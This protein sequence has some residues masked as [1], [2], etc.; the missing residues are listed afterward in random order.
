MAFLNCPAMSRALSWPFLGAEQGQTGTE[1]N[2]K[3]GASNWQVF[4]NVILANCELIAINRPTSE[5]ITAINGYQ[6]ALT[7][8]NR[9]ICNKLGQLTWKNAGIL[10]HQRTP[11]AR[12]ELQRNERRVYKDQILC[13]GGE[14]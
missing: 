14:I 7:G 11:I 2:K 3:L 6:Q 10:L 8:I 4:S 1:E 13:F 9:Y 12:F 5:K